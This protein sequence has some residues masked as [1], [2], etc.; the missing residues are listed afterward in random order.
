MFPGL[1]EGEIELVQQVKEA[2]KMEMFDTSIVHSETNHVCAMSAIDD[3]LSL[4][5]VVN[6]LLSKL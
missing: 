5:T 6:I 3:C 1:D 4:I 2:M